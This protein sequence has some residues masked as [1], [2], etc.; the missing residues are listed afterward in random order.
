M[1]IVFFA[2]GIR[3]YTCLKKLLADG[4]AVTFVVGHDT[5]PHDTYSAIT[6]AREHLIE[7]ACPSNPNTQEFERVLR[8]QKAD[9][10]VLAGYGMILKE[11]IISIPKKICINLHGG[12]L[13]EYRGSSPMNWALINGDRTFGLSIIKVDT[14]V[15]SG[16][17]LYAEEFPVKGNDT[18]VD[19]HRLA[20]EAFPQMLT[21]VL[22]K[23]KSE[24]FIAQPQD[25]S[26][27]QYYPLRFPDDGLI[28]FDQLKAEEIHNRIRALTE[29]YPCAFSFYKKRKVK[30]LSSCLQT[31]NFYGEP[32]RIYRKTEKGFL[33]CGM[34]KCLWITKAV[35]ADTGENVLAVV[36]KYEQMTTVRGFILYQAAKGDHV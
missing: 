19:L 22:G 21:A 34:D 13:P 16:P 27:A 2:K 29:P 31:G 23:I 9:V 12:K 17:V 35:F 15:D 10:F 6:L 20:N 28:L 1:D 33:I 32:G 25:A 14:G 30:L 11:N 24:D 5:D 36:K 18:I 26:K 7:V 4:Y 3:G 8:T